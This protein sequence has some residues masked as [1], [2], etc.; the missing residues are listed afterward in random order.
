MNSNAVIIYSYDDCLLL[1]CLISARGLYISVASDLLPSQ[2]TIEAR[3]NSQWP[4]VIVRVWEDGAVF[5][6]A[7]FWYPIY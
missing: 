5:P 1:E 3:R 7:K 2:P 4:T 6:L